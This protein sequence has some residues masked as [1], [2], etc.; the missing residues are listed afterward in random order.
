ME[1]CHPC[2]IFI[3]ETPFHCLYKIQKEGTS[4]AIVLSIQTEFT[5]PPRPPLLDELEPSLY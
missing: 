1:I 2:I 4:L 3:S 5:M